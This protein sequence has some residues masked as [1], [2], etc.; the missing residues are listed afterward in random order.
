MDEQ[1]KPATPK[2]GLTDEEFALLPT[3]YAANALEG[4]VWTTGKPA[5]FRGGV[6]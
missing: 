4:K 3:V 1:Q 2:P 6:T 5:Y